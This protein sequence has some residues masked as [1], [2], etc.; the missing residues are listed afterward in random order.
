MGGGRGNAHT[1]ISPFSTTLP[2]WKPRVPQKVRCARH[3]LTQTALE[4]GSVSCWADYIQ[5][6]DSAKPTSKAEV[7]SAE[8]VTARL[9]VFVGPPLPGRSGSP[10]IF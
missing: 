4:V 2:A 10:G 8:T 7:K 9:K 5:T 1:V 3:T 6:A